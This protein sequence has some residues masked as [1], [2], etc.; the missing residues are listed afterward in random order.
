M[1]E[2]DVFEGAGVRI[3]LKSDE[4]F[5]KIRESLTRIGVPSK[6]NVLW[7]SCHILHRQGQYAI[8]HFKE[9]FAQDGKPS[10]ITEEDYGRRNRIVLLL[11]E[12]NMCEII[13]KEE[14]VNNSSHI[15]NV[16]VIRYND[17][18]N[19]VLKP[20]YMMRSEMY[21]AIERIRNE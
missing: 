20:K 17:R 15:S 11:E 21:R 5:N 12:W 6:G 4:D 13:D 14:V 7:Q 18:M 1:N 16:K 9:M 10:S 8:L 19:W 3:R 2:E